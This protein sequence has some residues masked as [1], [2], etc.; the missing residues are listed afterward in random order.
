MNKPPITRPLAVLALL[1]ST[2]A[3]PPATAARALPERF[4]ATFVAEATGTTVARARWTL[5]PG[6]DGRYVSTS[7]TKSAGLLALI[8]KEVR[9]ERS[10]WRDTGD[11]L[12]PLT[13][14]YERTGRKA[15][16]I[17]ITFDWERNVAHHD[18]PDGP[19]K[20]PV[21]RGTMDKLGYILALMRDL[22]RGERQVEYTIA[23]GGQLRRYVLTAI[24]EER[25]ETALGTFDTVGMQLVHGGG[26]RKT[27]FWCASALGFFPVKIDHVERGGPPLTLRLDSL[28]GIGRHGSEKDTVRGESQKYEGSVSREGTGRE[29]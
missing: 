27:S 9:I 10:E 14:H 29:S 6:E 7:H 25:T 16:K 19:W 2:A 13:Y 11:W 12:Q 22:S 28:D 24:G 4:E 5:S 21:P 18:S 15:R 8:R 3:F 20:L 26:R 1:L 23:D 17:G